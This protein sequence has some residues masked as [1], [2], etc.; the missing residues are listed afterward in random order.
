MGLKVYLI[1]VML[2]GNESCFVSAFFGGSKGQ[3]ITSRKSPY[4][5]LT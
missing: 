5:M 2:N 1:S 4:C 3:S